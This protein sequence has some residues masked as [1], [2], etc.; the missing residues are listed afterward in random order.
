MLFV[1]HVNEYVATMREINKRAFKTELIQQRYGN[2][3]VQ[4]L[5]TLKI[6]IW[7]YRFSAMPMLDLG[8]NLT[9]RVPM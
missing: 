8:E 4:I 9:F 3:D 6:K 2:P 1:P 5:A 7:I